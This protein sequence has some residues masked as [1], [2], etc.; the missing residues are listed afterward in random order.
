MKIHLDPNTIYSTDGLLYWGFQRYVVRPFHSSNL[1]CLDLCCDRL[2]P[3]GTDGR[4]VYPPV[5]LDSFPQLCS[6]HRRPLMNRLVCDDRLTVICNTFIRTSHTLTIHQHQSFSL[7]YLTN[8]ISGFDPIQKVTEVSLI[9][10]IQPKMIELMLSSSHIM[11]TSSNGNIFRV[12]GP[13]YGEFT[14]H[15]WI[16][17]TKASDAELWCFLW[18]AP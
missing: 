7:G 16:S 11:M 17:R 10:E 2:S 3:Q 12:T 15:R 13:L 8:A 4:A 14:G 9:I 1:R 18:F 5:V 6:I